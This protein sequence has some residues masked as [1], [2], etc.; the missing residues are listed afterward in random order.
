MA[1]LIRQRNGSPPQPPSPTPSVTRDYDAIN[2]EY[3][4]PTSILKYH[5][6]RMRCTGAAV[7]VCACASSS[8]PRTR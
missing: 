8:S 5:E 4:I 1:A 3:R 2:T 7:F 6:R